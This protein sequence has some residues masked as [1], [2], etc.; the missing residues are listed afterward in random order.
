MTTVEQEVAQVAAW[1][2]EQ[3]AVTLFGEVGVKLIIHAGEV[4][5][6]EKS[7]TTKS[8]SAKLQFPG[9]RTEIDADCG[10]TNAR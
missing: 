9:K 7:I 6:V 8:L 2:R 3:A 1:L 10:S 4:S 5:R